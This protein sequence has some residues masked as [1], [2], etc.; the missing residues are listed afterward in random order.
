MLELV[1]AGRGDLVRRAAAIRAMAGG[2]SVERPVDMLDE[3]PLVARVPTFES[4]EQHGDHT[5]RRHLEHGAFVGAKGA[6]HRGAVEVAVPV[7]HNPALGLMPSS[8]T[9]LCITLKV[10]KVDMR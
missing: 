4:G 7:A 8:G 10:P 1:G 2:G 9:N 5:G 3:R 6:A